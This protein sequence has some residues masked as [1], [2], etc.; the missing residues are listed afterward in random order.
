VRRPPRPPEPF[1][2]G[3]QHERTS[4]A[5]ERTAIS[6]MVAATLLAR[7]AAEDGFWPVAGAALVLAA[8]GGGLLVWSG[9]HYDDL[10]G[11]LRAGGEVDHHRLIQVVGLAVAAV[12]AT[13]LVLS[14]WLAWRG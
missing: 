6:L 13:A 5:W 14:V 2:V 8:V 12:A 1:D 10:H 9:V 3:L 11:P 4:L 7:Y